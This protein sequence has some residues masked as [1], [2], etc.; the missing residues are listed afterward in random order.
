V[1]ARD[2]LTTLLARVANFLMSFALSVILA[3]SLGSEGMGAW[4]VLIA[5]LFLIVQLFGPGVAFANVFHV[6]QRK[7]TASE[8][9]AATLVLGLGCG[10]F[11]ILAGIAL[12]SLRFRSLAVIGDPTLA[13]V[14]LISVPFIFVSFWGTKILQG[15]HRI[16]LMNLLR[17][18]AM[19]AMLLF[20]ALMVG[21]LKEGLWGAVRAQVAGHLCATLML[22]LTL[23]RF[24][25]PGEFRL[26][27]R[28]VRSSLVYGIK[29]YVGKVS[30][31]A[32]NRIDLLIAPL[33]LTKQEI[34]LYFIAVVVTEKLWMIPDAMSQAV[35][36][37]ISADPEGRPALTAQ[38][39]RT[40][41][42]LMLPVAAVLVGAGWWLFPLVFGAAF[43]G[44][45]V[46][47]LAILPGA[48][49]LGLGR[50]LM[51]SLVGTNRPGT[52]SAVAGAGAACN[53]LLNFLLIPKFGV[54]GCSLASTGSYTFQMLLL[55]R[56]HCRNHHVSAYSVVGIQRDDFRV[57]WEQA[58]RLLQWRPGHAGTAVGSE[59]G[60]A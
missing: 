26:R 7:L 38:A 14:L 52:L 24:I 40:A 19:A 32:N 56:Y 39:C 36:P 13:I 49:A 46:P 6:A 16:G 15:L 31:W 60:N 3:R 55:M 17:V 22:A 53:V 5:F 48:I 59:A 45:Y 28:A 34:G 4:G 18:G 25:E 2:S 51:A 8:A 37:R 29:M 30:D 43:R 21:V 41:L 33:F 42:I 12:V 44:A 54:V 10:V 50:I 1:V 47:M 23:S 9:W 58:R 20:T 11:G 35:L 57:L 27:W